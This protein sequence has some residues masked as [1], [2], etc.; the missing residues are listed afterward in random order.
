M[1]K[2]LLLC[3]IFISL[4]LLVARFSTLVMTRVL[5]VKERAGIRVLS[6][7]EGADVIINGQVLG[8]TP[9]ENNNMD[10]ASFD[11]KIL[12]IEGSWDG[13]VELKSGT[14]AVINRE[15]AKEQASASGEVLTLEKG[16]GV[17][18][19]SSP[20]A[21]DVE[22]D[23]KS[24]GQTPILVNVSP[25]E[26][27]FI[28]SKANFLK[29]SIKAIIPT[30]FNLTLNVDLALSEADL[31]AVATPVLT[32]TPKVVIIKT[33]TGFLR[34]REKASIGSKEI[35]RVKT[36]D[37]LTL[38]EELTGWFRIRMSDGK[39]GYISSTYAQKKSN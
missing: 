37:E 35:G 38:L 4:T 22:V 29:R 13:Q 28:L 7:P 20:S 10:V 8:K 3:V 14:L 21:V 30:G 2:A 9:F 18:V 17:T 39:E 23:G 34:V 12:G 25:G 27:T 1:K 33:P 36:G 5:G 16:E 6:K 15:L 26:H 31:T 11:V 24:Y 32:M 19:I